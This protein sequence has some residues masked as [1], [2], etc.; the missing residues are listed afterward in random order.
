MNPRQLVTV[1]R[2]REHR[3]DQVRLVLAQLL[4]EH[5][6][7]GGRIEQTQAEQLALLAELRAASALGKIDVDRM[8]AA[9]Y[10]IGRLSIEIARLTASREAS[11]RHLQAARQAFHPRPEEK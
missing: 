7:I 6:S 2:V 1:R 10:H 5:S 3:R 8:V 11:A 4:A 9:R